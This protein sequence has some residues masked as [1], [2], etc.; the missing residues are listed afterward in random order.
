MVLSLTLDVGSIGCSRPVERVLTFSGSLVGR[1]GEV[2]RRQLDR[3]QREN[4]SL[5]I[6]LRPT[7]DAADQRHQLYVQWLNARAPDPDVLQLDVIWTPEFAAAGWVQ[8]LEG[9]RPPTDLFF[10]NAVAANRWDGTL[11]ALPW[12]VDVGMLYWRTDLL[13]HA[14]RDFAEL[15]VL[16][17]QALRAHA[18]PFG[19][20]WQGARYE[21]LV[22]VFLEQLTA[23]GGR[24]LDENDRVAIDSPSA[25]A[26]LTAMRDLVHASGVSPA[27]VLTWQEE[28]TRF[29]FQ[30]GDAVL[31]R[32][33]PYAYSL[34]QDASNRRSPAGSPSRRCRRDLGGRRPARS[35]DRS[36]PSTR[37]ANSRTRPIG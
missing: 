32:S 2:I 7:P 1:E 23:F 8:S 4:P 9:F 6:A 30:N 17:Q 19:F 25:V 27:A 12:F 34:L 18:L 21:G 28:Q 3:F 24:I 16:A 5:S 33:W 10:A 31:M 11:Y 26:A 22:T 35:E 29:A 36:S 14:P 20:V 37:S 15:S 13:P